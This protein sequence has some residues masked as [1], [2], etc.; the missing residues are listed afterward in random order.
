[1]AE[2]ILSTAGAT[3][4]PFVSVPG[5]PNFRDIGGYTVHGSDAAIAVRKNYIYRCVEQSRITVDGI[6]KIRSLGVTHVYDL[7]S[8]T[9][10][11]KLA[12]S[13]KRGYVEWDGCKRVFAPVFADKDYSPESIAI[14]YRNYASGCTEVQFNFQLPD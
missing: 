3:Q 7:R 13:G 11:D 10:I 8:Q 14:R 6:N 5:V 9:E 12:A 2:S 1:M 4:P